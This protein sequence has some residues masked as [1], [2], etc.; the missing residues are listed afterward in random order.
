MEYNFEVN[1]P[2]K[3][4]MEAIVNQVLSRHSGEKLTQDNL[5]RWKHEI[6]N[7][8]LKETTLEIK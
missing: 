2:T 7:I 3:E 8:I 1:L 4:R 5:E 6:A